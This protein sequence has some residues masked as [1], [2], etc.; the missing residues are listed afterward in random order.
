MRGKPLVFTTTKDGCIVSTSHCLNQD[1]YLRVSDPRYTGKGRAPHVMYHRYV[2][3]YFKGSIPEGKEIHHKCHNRACCNLDHLE[4]VDIVEHKCEHNQTRY[5][6]R[7]DAAHR[8]WK[9]NPTITGVALAKTFGVSDSAA[10]KWIKEW[11]CRD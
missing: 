3:E 7:K 10:C 8:Y 2:W 11:K 1:G 6:P 4:L 5:K 9:D